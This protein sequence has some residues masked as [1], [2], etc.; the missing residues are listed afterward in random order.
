MNPESPAVEA[1][2]V[3]KSVYLCSCGARRFQWVATNGTIVVGGFKPDEYQ[4]KCLGCG[5]VHSEQDVKKFFG[6]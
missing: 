2:A 3:N 5:R 4:Y 6:R 1:G